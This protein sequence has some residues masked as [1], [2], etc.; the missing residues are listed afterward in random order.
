MKK[1]YIIFI[2]L[3]FLTPAFS[4]VQIVQENFG[5]STYDGNPADYPD[6]TSD[7]VFSGDDSHL[8]RTENSSGYS[9][10]SGG[11]AVLMGNWG[12][13]ENTEF[14]MQYNT[15]QYTSVRLSFGFTHN[16]DGWGVCQ[17]TN[18]YTEIEYST[19]GEN[20]TTIDKASLMEGSSWPC[21]DENVWAFV[22]LA[23]ILPSSASL[24]IRFTHTDPDIHPYYIDDI[25]LTGFSPDASPPTTPTNL[26]SEAVSFNS[27]ILSWNVSSDDNAVSYYEIFRNG[28]YFT[29]VVD[30]MTEIQYLTPGSTSEFVIIAYDIADNA[31]APSSSIDVTLSSIPN[32]YQYSWQKPQA[33]IT[34]EGDLEWQPEAFDFEQGSPVRYID[35][36]NGDDNQDGMTK[37]TPWKHHPWDDSAT[38]NAANCSG[39]HTYVFKK[40]VVYRGTL[41]AKESGSPSEPVRLTSDP[42]WGNGEAYF[43]GSKR[44]TDGWTQADVSAAPN[45]PEPDKV[46]YRDGWLPETKIVCELDDDNMNQL[47][48]ARSPNYQYTPDD[49]LKTWW[50]M[51]RKQEQDGNLWLTD[52]NNLTQTDPSYY[53]GATVWSQE[54]AIVMCTVWAQDVQE[55]DP[56]NNRVR[57]NNTNFGG[58]GSHYFIENTPFLLDTTSEFYYDKDAQRLFVRLEGDKDP[59][60]TTIEVATKAQLIE[61]ENKHDIEISGLTFGF[62]TANSVHY[63]EE[64]VKSTIRMTGICSNIDISNNKFLY[65]NGGVSLKN[66]GS[67]DLNSHSITVKDN[68]FQNMGDHAIVFSTSSVYLDDIHILRNNVYNNGYRHLGRWYSSI[69]AIFGQL[70]YG[71][72]AGNIIDVSWGNGIDMF[73]GKGGGSNLYVPFVRGFIHQNKASNTLIGTNDYGGIESW[74][75][76]PTYCYNNYSHN[77]SGYKHY[78]NSSIGYAYYFDGAFKHIVFNNI[79]SGVSH[80]RNSA[81]IMQVLGFYNMYVHNTGYNTNTFL[82]AWKGT[83]ALNGHNTYLSNVAEDVG[84]FFRHEI[85][86]DYIPFESYGYNVSSKNEYVGSLENRDNDL[87][88]EEFRN[89]LESYNSQLTQTGLNAAATVLADAESHDFRPVETS[90]AIDRGVK[91]FTP[92]PLAKVVGEWHFYKHPA[93]LSIIMADNFYMTNEFNDRTTYKN[94]PK[95][96]LK[97]H[98][99]EESNFVTGDLEDWTEGALKFDGSSVYCSISH[100]EASSTRA[101]DVDMTDNHF[102]IEVYLKTGDGHTNGAIVS[103]YGGSEGY[104][105]GI[106]ASGMAEMALYAEG[107]KVTSQASSTTLNDGNWHHILAE[108]NRRAGIN[109]YIDGTLS[110]GSVTGTMP[111]EN[112]SLSN[113]AD[114]LVAKDA[115]DNYFEGT[116]DF[117]R[118]SKGS[119]F[120]AKTTIHELYEWTTNGPFLYDMRGN[121]PIGTRDAGALE[122]AGKSCDLSVSPDLI[123]F[124][125]TSSTKEIQITPSDEFE[126]DAS[127]GDFF[128]TIISGNGIEVTVNENPSFEKRTGSLTIIGCNESKTVT[129]EQAGSICVFNLET[130]EFNIS[131]EEQILGVKVSTNGELKVSTDAEFII[132]NIDEAKDSISVEVEANESETERTAEIE[133][134]GCDESYTVTITQEGTDTYIDQV[135]PEGLD[136]YPNPVHDNQFIIKVPAGTRTYTYRISDLT[137]KIIQMEKTGE[138]SK[139]VH[140]NSASG[141]YILEIIS[142][143]FDYRT[144]ITLE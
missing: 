70:N 81:C 41:T 33:N 115:E 107:S 112:V 12:S 55:W 19:D 131:A 127:T 125:E 45:I 89:K 82:N 133:I 62:T 15:S 25:T 46:W 44:F 108:V 66:E 22:E 134:E 78:N 83:L 79:A 102:I 84:T 123:L 116:I 39:I 68:D 121:A 54:D 96:H 132:V 7:A 72:V 16:S 2:L 37:S 95:N 141:V 10:A 17:L 23:E 126:I 35:Y 28:E 42:S 117:L 113:T 71:E 51:T 138:S 128:T 73:W 122:V 105:L 139:T 8:F 100:S 9:Q 50:T 135:K 111:E 74:Q 109:M 24:F 6:Y 26:K 11:V 87:S 77:A 43:F 60:T 76:G 103:K 130:T 40:G 75:G 114:L 142:E 101:N 57:V 58:V 59:N 124:D 1:I 106:D 65:M 14:I 30:T 34:P 120:D 110:N 18:N 29:T 93:D 80:N 5:S 144:K 99:V 36:E 3:C 64:D 118:I 48:L 97:A 104:K 136:I 53:E 129:I 98:Q 27:F 119:L 13:D 137:G 91:F 88:L 86:P 47:H 32:D 61:I 38:G 67:Q 85:S 52:R 4:Q 20:W 49:P 56:D 90:E 94:V 92:F 143:K 69:P 21:A 63:G 31:S 140:L